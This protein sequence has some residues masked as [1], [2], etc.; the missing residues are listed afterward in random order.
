MLLQPLVLEAANSSGILSAA[1][2]IYDVKGQMTTTSKPAA[3][4]AR[5]AE[6]MSALSA[7]NT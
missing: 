6:K 4:F 1:E 2:K 5:K 3:D 7:L